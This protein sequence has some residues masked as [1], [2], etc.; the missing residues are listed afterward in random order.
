MK[1][2]T[3]KIVDRAFSGL[4]I[5]SILLLTA[6]LLAILAPMVIRGS[7]A[8]VFRGT[9]EYRRMMFEKFGR[10]NLTR[11]EAE[12]E[13]ARKVRQPI[14]EMVN[15]FHQEV[16]QRRDALREEKRAIR[17]DRRAIRKA[18]QTER[19]K[20]TAKL[21]QRKAD[22]ENHSRRID[23]QTKDFAEVNTLLEELFGQPPG[24]KKHVLWEKQYG[25]TRW[26]GVQRKIDLLIHLD[27]WVEPEDPKQPNRLVRTPRADLYAGTA[28]QPLFGYVQS[29]SHELFL[30]EWTFYWQ[31]LTDTSDAGHFFGGI[32]PEILGTL[33][34]TIGAMLFAVPMGVISAVYLVEYAKDG[35]LVRSIR[36][37]TNT[38]AG[39]PSI[40]FGLFGAV[41][42]I[43][44]LHISSGKSVL[45]GSI[46]LALLI[47]PMV[48]RASE[49]AIRAVPQTYKE[50]ALSLGAGKWRTVVSVILPAS[51]PGILT[52]IVISMGRAAGETAPIIFTA[53]VSIGKPL[54]LG[55]VFD[56]PTPALPWNIYNICNE[57][58]AVEEIRHVQYGMVLTLVTIVLLLNL[59]AIIMRARIS[60]KLR[61]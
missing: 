57:H 38:L 44:T 35:W 10:G 2:G 53:V 32:W 21:Q 8:F 24:E 60:R 19:D 34:L 46:T 15:A 28:L 54:S 23:E 13:E 18:D 1:L 30:P 42:F 59:A 27:R 47:L 25:Q 39:V 7:K 36:T 37:F 16:E 3:R 11:I 22:L 14:Y 9:V 50:A 6:A 55:Q 43:G 12:Q 51:L 17:R 40:V 29:H 48:I 49:E 58:E 5:T 52:G 45:V 26:D 20:L 61:S 4:G 33:Y 41:F 31:F 56:Q